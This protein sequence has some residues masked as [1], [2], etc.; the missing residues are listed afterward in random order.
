MLDELGLEYKHDTDFLFIQFDNIFWSHVTLFFLYCSLPSLS[1]WFCLH[2]SNSTLNK[3]RPLVWSISTS[4]SQWMTSRFLLFF[5]FF[6]FSFFLRST[7]LSLPAVPW[8][9][10]YRQWH[11]SVSPLTAV[12]PELHAFPLYFLFYTP[13]PCTRRDPKNELAAGVDKARNWVM[14]W[15]MD[16]TFRCEFRVERF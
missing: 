12:W 13:Q 7:V 8:S 9:H 15:L 11:C 5:S 10:S 14:G 2:S 3:N 4:L 1:P 6:S 16:V